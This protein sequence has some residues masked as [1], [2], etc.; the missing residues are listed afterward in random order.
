MQ[1]LIRRQSFFCFGL[2]SNQGAA[3]VWRAASACANVLDTRWRRGG[4]GAMGGFA[5][6]S[7]SRHVGRPSHNKN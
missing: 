6:P 5:F 4:W 2:D 3:H 7:L 1:K